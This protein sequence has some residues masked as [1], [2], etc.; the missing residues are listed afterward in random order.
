MIR[1]RIDRLISERIQEPLVADIY[2]DYKCKGILEAEEGI[3]NLIPQDCIDPLIHSLTTHVTREKGVLIFNTLERVVK[4]KKKLA[5]ISAST[6]LLWS[7]SLLVDDIIDEDTTR[8]NKETGWTRFGKE[9]TMESAKAALSAVNETVLSNFGPEAGRQMMSSVNI[10]MQS[11]NSP[12]I[13]N[14]DTTIDTIIEN[15]Q[16]RGLFHCTFPIVALNEIENLGDNA[17]VLIGA[18]HC[19]N[20]AGQILNDVKDILPTN[21]NRRPHFSDVR[22][23]TMTIPILM[24]CNTLSLEDKEK[25]RLLFGSGVVNQEDIQ[26]LHSL[27]ESNFPTAPVKR[28]VEENYERFVQGIKKVAGQDIVIVNRWVKYKKSQMEA[29]NFTSS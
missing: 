24:T 11:L 20:L 16:E 12:S 17:K 19:N 23:G 14:I 13:R 21:L 10:G 18:L 1:D 2:S 8:A 4:D 5:L 9:A 6:E 29:M 22:S 3:L 26:Y 25:V 28:L 27:V 15:I 7:T